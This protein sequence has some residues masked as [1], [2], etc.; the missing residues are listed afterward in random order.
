MPEVITQCT[1]GQLPPLRFA[2]DEAAAVAWLTQALYSHDG[3][4]DEAY[5]HLCELDD[6]YRPQDEDE[7]GS[8]TFALVASARDLGA[9]TGPGEI[10]FEFSDDGQ[11]EYG[12]TCAAVP[13]PA[14]ALERL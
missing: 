6:G 11:G 14:E 10:D 9:I 1:C 2:L 5:K 8:S 7:S 4:L 3:E 12:Y 13:G